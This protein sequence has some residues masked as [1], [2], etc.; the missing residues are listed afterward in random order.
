MPGKQSQIN[1]STSVLSCGW[2]RDWA[3][4]EKGRIVAESAQPGAHTSAVA[5]RWG[6]ITGH[7]RGEFD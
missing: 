3:P 5:R 4:A 7:W 6:V 2:R 1:K